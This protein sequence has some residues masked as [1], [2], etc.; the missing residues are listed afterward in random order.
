MGG[1]RVFGQG[2]YQGS[3][4]SD[5]CGEITQK[6]DFLRSQAVSGWDRTAMASIIRGTDGDCSPETMRGPGHV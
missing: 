1:E 6:T 2:A 4:K 3:G 5:K